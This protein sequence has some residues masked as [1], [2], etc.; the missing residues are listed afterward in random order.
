MTHKSE[1]R[2]SAWLADAPVFMVYGTDKAMVDLLKYSIVLLLGTGVLIPIVVAV[3]APPDAPPFLLTQAVGVGM[4]VVLGM[5]ALFALLRRGKVRLVAVIV[6]FFLVLAT[7]VSIAGVGSLRN[8][9]TVGYFLPLIL[10][11]LLLGVDGLVVFLA[12]VFF[13]MAGLYWAEIQEWIVSAPRVMDGGDLVMLLLIFALSTLL[14]RFALNGLAK[15]AVRSRQNIADL[16]KAQCELEARM[17]LNLTQQEQLQ[18]MIDRERAQSEALTQLLE[19]VR[20][21]AD[22]LEMAAGEI[23]MA[24]Q[25]QAAGATQQ[26]LAI[27]NT[28]ATIEQVRATVDLV[29]GRAREVHGASERTVS[30]S[31]AGAEA[32]Q[33]TVSSMLQIKKQVEG[34]ARNAVGLFDLTKQ[35]EEILDAVNDLA[36][37]SNI[38]ALNAAVEAARAGE[39]GEGFSV[40]ATE[41][42]HLATQSRLA[43][44]Q[45]GDILLQIHEATQRMVMVTQEGARSVDAGITRLGQVQEA[46]AL[47]TQVINESAQAVLQMVN[48]ERQQSSG[49]EQISEAMREISQ[50]TQQNLITSTQAEHSAQNLNQLARRLNELVIRCEG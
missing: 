31:Q 23:I 9:A 19:Q 40:V 42:R 50:A 25:Q 46:I 5:L 13:A 10:A 30:V 34:I 29:V 1:P 41:V 20:L 33:D 24:T 28:A 21:S 18:Q 49:V 26:S 14:L 6:C 12:M 15:Q 37:Q 2:L 35:I 43:T 32:V 11:G 36:T 16:E 7:T 22:H 38:L 39:Q 45:V 48:S 4:T 27:S 8:I 3:A 44:Q 17:T 47:L